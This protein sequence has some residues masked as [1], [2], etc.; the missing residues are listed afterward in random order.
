MVVLEGLDEVQAIND[1]LLAVLALVVLNPGLA[2]LGLEVEG[3]QDHAV[4][5]TDGQRI[6]IIAQLLLE[7]LAGGNQIIIGGGNLLNTGLLEGVH[8][9]V[10]DTA[11]HRD[12]HSLQAIS[13][14][15]GVLGGIA[16]LAQ[17]DDIAVLAQIDELLT[18]GAVLVQPVPVDLHDIG[19]LVSGQRGG[20]LLFPAGPCAVGG[21]DGDVGILLVESLQSLLVS[22]MAG[23]AAPPADG[24]LD[25]IGGV[26]LVGLAGG[27]LS[28]RLGSGA[29]S[30]G[31]SLAGG[32]GA[33]GSGAAASQQ[34]GGHSSGNAKG[35]CLLH[36][37]VLLKMLCD[38]FLQIVVCGCK[39]HNICHSL[40]YMIAKR[41]NKKNSQ[42]S[43]FHLKSEQ[44]LLCCL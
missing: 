2:V 18:R 39:H 34:S 28:G 13:N 33:A 22:L 25:R 41:T 15:A 21:G 17:V 27:S 35:N 6:V 40:V 8:V 4:I 16:P 23:V 10:E 37:L 11:G 20:L 43:A 30:S 9:P 7:G 14:G 29:F 12:G 5:L 31:S 38:L 36:C 42:F 1:L 44:F 26:D 3:H 24:Q 32:G 19:T